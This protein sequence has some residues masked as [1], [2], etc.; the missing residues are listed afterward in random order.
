M[1]TVTVACAA[2]QVP[3][4]AGRD[5]VSTQNIGSGRLAPRHVWNRDS[6]VAGVVARGYRL[7]DSWEVRE[8]QFFIPNDS[9]RSFGPYS[10]L[11]F[12]RD[13]AVSAIA[14]G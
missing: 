7:V 14:L 3:L 4:Y 8:R 2:Q 6:F 13:D 1:S 11:Y 12:V 9:A 10:G 5:S